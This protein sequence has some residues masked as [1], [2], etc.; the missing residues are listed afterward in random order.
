MT[1]YVYDNVCPKICLGAYCVYFLLS[2]MLIFC[3]FDKISEK[4]QL[5]NR[6]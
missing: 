4:E 1:T 3:P 2:N 6:R 5:M